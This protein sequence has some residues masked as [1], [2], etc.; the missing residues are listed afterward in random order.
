MGQKAQTVKKGRV[1]WYDASRGYGFVRQADTGA[2]V[3]L[4]KDAL[5]DFGLSGVQS[6]AEIDYS[7]FEGVNSSRVSSIRK[8]KGLQA[9]S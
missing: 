2:S 6:G 7:A 5:S 9:L 3:F 4:T 8:L 1:L